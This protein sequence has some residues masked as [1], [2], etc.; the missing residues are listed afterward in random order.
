M[1]SCSSEA[2]VENSV[3]NRRSC[4]GSESSWRRI[5]IASSLLIGHVEDAIDA[6]RRCFFEDRANLVAGGKL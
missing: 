4:C 1:L 5:L 6:R 2:S 3:L